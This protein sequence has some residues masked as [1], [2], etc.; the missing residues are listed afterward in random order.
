MLIG[1][2]DLQGAVKEHSCMLQKCGCNTKNIKTLTEL[3]NIDG[4]I[5]PGGESTTL[6]NLMNQ[7][8]L[9]EKIKKLGKSGLPIMGTCAGLILLSKEIIDGEKRQKTLG[10]IDIAAKRNAFGRQKESFETFL[11][12]E[13]IG[14][15]PFPGVFIRAPIIARAGKEVEILAKFENKII[16]ARQGNIIALAFHPELTDDT[17]LHKYFIETIK[18]R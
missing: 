17:R 2:L 10:L 7:Y 16:G 11:K 14:E 8:G 15:E 5:I 1:I 18:G 4:L 13:N 12:I 6:C 9:F 3:S